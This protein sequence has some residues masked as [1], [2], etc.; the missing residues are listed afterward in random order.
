M[1]QDRLASEIQ[2]LVRKIERNKS[3]GYST[4]KLESDLKRKLSQVKSKVS[5]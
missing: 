2:N 1:Y 5:I 4:V 3:K